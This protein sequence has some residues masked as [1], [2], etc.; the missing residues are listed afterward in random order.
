[1][2]Q[3]L[4]LHAL[5]GSSDHD[6]TGLINGQILYVQDPTNGVQST[7]IYTNGS[8]GL[9]ATT[10]SITTL[11]AGTMISGSTNLYNIFSTAGS[12]VQ[13]VGAN[14][15]L[16]T[17]GT[18]TNPTIILA[19]SPSFNNLT[20]SGTGNFTGTLQSGGTNLYDI[21]TEGVGTA[22]VL[23]LWS[24]NTGLLTN[25]IIT[26]SGTGVT[27]AGSVNIIGDVNVLGTATTFNT[28]TVQSQDN[29]IL[30]NF[31]GSYVSALGGGITVLS[32]TP[33]GVASTWSI[34]A[35]GSWSSNTAILTSAIT[36]NGGNIAVTGGGAMTSGGTNLYNIFATAGS[37]VQSVGANGNLSTGGTATNPT[38]ILAASPSFNNLTVSGAT[39][40]QTLSATTMISGS[41]NLYNIFATAGS[42]V[43]SVG[44]NGNLSTG[45]TATNPTIIL[46][47]SPSFNDLTVSGNTTTQGISGTTIYAST[48]FQMTPYTGANPTS[49][50]NND[51][52]FYSAAT[53]IITLNYRVG[54]ATKSVELS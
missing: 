6:T 52:W 9:T 20:V 53:G 15:N 39:S 33:S 14:G 18:A 37:G 36:V 46:A 16:S 4:K 19:A 8:G 42:G 44:A 32:G 25:S 11:S 38:I 28:Q 3:H 51:V 31:S 7:G 30:L 23:P 27:V 29:N 5:T 22:N 12:G 45:G 2:A 47:A 43:Q 41:T 40:L 35:N 50:N 34:D 10:A 1:M 54:G 13:S 21:F 24:N 26:Q 17:G 49:P 48:F